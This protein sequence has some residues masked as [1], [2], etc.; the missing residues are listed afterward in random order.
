MFPSLKPVRTAPTATATSRTCYVSASI[1]RASVVNVPSQLR[2]L[3]A[4]P[5]QRGAKLRLRHPPPGRRSQPVCSAAAAA[6]L[7]QA[8]GAWRI[9][10]ALSVAAA[11][12]F[13]CGFSIQITILADLALSWRRRPP[14]STNGIEVCE[15]MTMMLVQSYLQ[16]GAHA[17]RQGAERVSLPH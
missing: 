17:S 3:P 6:T 4:L 15:D 5:R 10:T 13:W 11:L 14:V 12:G 7:G 1:A 16:V 9:W 8:S 2:T